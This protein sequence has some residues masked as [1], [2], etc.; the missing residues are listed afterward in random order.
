ME[1]KSVKILVLS[2]ITFR[3]IEK[4]NIANTDKVS[5]FETLNIIFL[6]QNAV[7]NK[8][9]MYKIFAL[10]DISGNVL[11][12]TKKLFAITTINKKIYL[13]INDI[14]L[15]TFNLYN[16]VF[17]YKYNITKINI[18]IAYPSFIKFEVTITSEDF[19]IID[20]TSK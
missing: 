15:F 8:I 11:Y 19:C 4:P 20:N 5:L 16:F 2:N 6:I 17:I 18:K 3:I 9:N 1:N 13:Y 14:F 7:I 10:S 12:K